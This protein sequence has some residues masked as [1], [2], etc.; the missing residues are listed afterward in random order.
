MIRDTQSRAT[1]PGTKER[2]AVRKA[3]PGSH[4][5]TPETQT[6]PTSDQSSE[7][8]SPG[9]A[10]LEDGYNIS[11]PD[12]LGDLQ[13]ASFFARSKKNRWGNPSPAMDLAPGAGRHHRSKKL[14]ASGAK[15][16]NY[17]EQ[18]PAPNIN[19]NDIAMQLGLLSEKITSLSQGGQ[20]MGANENSSETTMQLFCLSEKMSSLSFELH[21]LEARVEPAMHALQ[22]RPLAAQGGIKQHPSSFAP[23]VQPV[24]DRMNFLAA[25]MAR[26]ENFL[27][28]ECSRIEREL[29]RLCY[30]TQASILRSKAEQLGDLLPQ[31]RMLKSL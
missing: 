26:N 18:F 13:P 23:A 24:P 21:K 1:K 14:G 28:G 29:Q 8:S 27:A 22:H 10:L 11:A 30:L 4:Q 25:E 19:T 3:V 16:A 17:Q 7:T 6:P 12:C 31:E 2:R 5:A 15:V 20:C 9:N